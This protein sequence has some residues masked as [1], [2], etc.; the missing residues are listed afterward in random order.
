MP[1]V[2]LCE[3]MKVSRSGYYKWKITPKSARQV[4]NEQISKIIRKEFHKSG[5]KFG[6]RIITMILKRKYNIQCNH[7]RVL[8]LM[9]SMN[10]RSIIRRKTKGCTIVR[11]NKFEENILNR[12]FKADNINEKWVTDVTYLKYGEN[13]E[14]KAYLSAVK[15]LHNGEI[16]SW[17]VSKTNDN[18]LVM[19]TIKAAIEANPGVTPILHSDRSFQ[20]TSKEYVREV[21]KV[22][23][24]RSMS[25]VGRC[26]DNAPMESF[27]SHFKDEYYYDHTFITYE[28]LVSGIAGY[29]NY[30]N[31][32][33]Y[34]WKLKS[35]TPVEYRNQAA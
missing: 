7:K 15:D 1:V 21:S 5:D 23:I 19:K 31:N 11:G 12:D 27:W 24:T 6:Y 9:R 32:E 13:E 8:R 10:L 2:I 33:H 14:H 30:Y 34:Q 4:E 26:I 25:R 20:Y 35:L 28:E 16:I 3:I 18:P 29:I 17:V 22:G